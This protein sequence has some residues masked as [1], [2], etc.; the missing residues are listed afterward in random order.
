MA[1]VVMTSPAR[2]TLCRTRSHAPHAFAI[3]DGMVELKAP[4]SLTGTTQHHASTAAAQDTAAAVLDA[5]ARAVSAAAGFRAAVATVKAT[6]AEVDAAV[7]LDRMAAA[8]HP[9]TSTHPDA[10]CVVRGWLPAA[11]SGRG[12]GGGSATHGS[13]W[14]GRHAWAGVA[15]T[16]PVADDT[17]LT[18]GTPRASTGT[19][20]RIRAA[21]SPRAGAGILRRAVSPRAASAVGAPS[22]VAGL[23]RHSS[24]SSVGSGTGHQGAG[25]SGVAHHWLP[26]VFGAFARRRVAQTLRLDAAPR[27]GGANT[28]APDAGAPVVLGAAGIV[29]SAAG[30][31]RGAG[32]EEDASGSSARVLG[33]RR[34]VHGGFMAGPLVRHSPASPRSTYDPT[35]WPCQV[36]T[37]RVHAVTRGDT[38]TQVLRR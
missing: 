34:C 5:P 35:V 38:R 16:V 6:A 37:R 12:G 15:A 3:Q 25:Q 10:G 31:G 2:F 26:G 32:G 17:P 27:A 36:P 33:T 24:A 14:G 4:A 20:L 18:V 13:A 11:V 8:L 23:A 30:T 1:V 9:A 19:G 21:A 22:P 28:P 29:A 7:L